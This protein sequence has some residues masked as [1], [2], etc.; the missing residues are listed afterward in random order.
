M[1]RT[2]TKTGE[3]GKTSMGTLN[4]ANPQ[5]QREEQSFL[6]AEREIL[7]RVIVVKK[8]EA[9]SPVRRQPRAGKA[10]ATPVW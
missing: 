1:A 7:V 3:G 9:R 4:R 6:A 2:V 8:M 5:R 10:A